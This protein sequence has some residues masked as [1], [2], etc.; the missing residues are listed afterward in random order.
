MKIAIGSDNLGGQLRLSLIDHLQKQSPVEVEIQDFGV[1]LDN[2]VDY[3]NIG[4][5]VA[6]SIA[7][8]SNQR[9]ILI[10]GTGIGMA[11][12]A[13]KVPG[14]YAANVSDSYSAER[15]RKSNNAQIIT[16]GALTVGVALAKTLIDVWLVSDFQGGQSTRK[17]NKIMEI[18]NKFSANNEK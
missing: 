4:L 12:T 14:V 10:C 17:I 16:L 18:E 8:G 11:I 13:N 1:N 15:A 6:E 7:N 5:L 2:D 3:P 9:G